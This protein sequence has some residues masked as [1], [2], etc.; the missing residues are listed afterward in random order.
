M[1]EKATS[2]QKPFAM[3]LLEKGLFSARA[4]LFAVISA[5][6]FLPSPATA[7]IAAAPCNPTILSQMNAKAVQHTMQESVQNQAFV[8]R[9]D[10]VLEYS[11]FARQ[12]DLGGTK[13]PV[14]EF[15][16]PI[17]SENTHWGMIHDDMHTDRILTNVVST[18]L[19]TYIPSQFPYN[20]LGNRSTRRGCDQM[21]QVWQEAKCR[22]FQTDPGEG[23][24]SFE[25]YAL[26]ADPRIMPTTGCAKPDWNTYNTA[27]KTGAWEAGFKTEVQTTFANVI[28]TLKPGACGAP[29]LLQ[30]QVRLEGTTEY[31]DGFCIKP[32]CVYNPGPPA[33]CQ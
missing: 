28:N 20:Y 12:T 19:A 5:L 15:M 10:S 23:Y 33:T 26:I 29:I 31:P 25:Q 4:P 7:Q 6:F 32:G 14:G 21:A 3:A 16:A 9:P 11:C 18:P 1:I 13:S 2:L 17:F 24:F 22:N 27:A 30:V 8:V